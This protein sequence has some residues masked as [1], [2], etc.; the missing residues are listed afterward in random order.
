MVGA[1]K[2]TEGKT[3]IE[4]QT[5]AGTGW[6]VESYLA[7][8]ENAPDT[9]A[10]F[11]RGDQ[12]IIS[13]DSVR[14][15]EAPGTDRS[16]ITTLGYGITGQVID[17]PSAADNLYWARIDTNHGTGWVAEAFLK[18]VEDEVP[19][20]EASFVI[21]DRVYVDTDGINLRAIPAS[22]GDRITILYRN[23]S[24]TVVEGPQEADG[25]IWYRIETSTGTG[26]G[27]G[28]FLSL[29]ESDPAG[30]AAFGIGDEVSVSTDRMHLRD[31]PGLA[32]T[33][34]LVIVT[35]ERGL[36]LDGPRTAD[37]YVWYQVETEAGTGWGVG[38][39]LTLASSAPTSG[40][41]ARVR[42]GELNLRR[43]PDAESEII[44]VLPDGAFV[45]V[46][47]GTESADGYRWVKVM[48][49]TYGSGWSVSE[50]L[51]RV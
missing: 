33:S 22:D 6:I 24:G 3:W 43:E 27:V 29:D 49:G 30:I 2:V 26:W 17:P 50:Y 14:L 7:P 31:A 36:V 13:S 12:V 35:G 1:A 11:E 45:D 8:S 5:S 41:R 51:E 47:D 19:V 15:R 48:S 23:A 39:F 20:L 34:T 25:Y 18:P 16:V 32:G 21:G 46:M 28:N 44:A 10:R 37:G 4:I 9:P 42:D 38:S 40:N